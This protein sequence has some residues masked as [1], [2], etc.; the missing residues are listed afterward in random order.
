MD[1]I[2]HTKL[3]ILLSIP[4]FKNTKDAIKLLIDKLLMFLQTNLHFG[5]IRV[6]GKKS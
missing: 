4:S 3:Q 1:K 5:S 2:S 6:S